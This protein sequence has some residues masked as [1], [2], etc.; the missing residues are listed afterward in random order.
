M[1]RNELAIET[2]GLNQA[3]AETIFGNLQD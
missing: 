1:E 3:E 2:L